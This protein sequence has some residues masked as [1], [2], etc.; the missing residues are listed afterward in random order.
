[1][2]RTAAVSGPLFCAFAIVL[3][4]FGS[5][6]LSDLLTPDRLQTW[7]TAARY[8][9]FQGLGLLTVAGLTHA[10]NLQM[11][12]AVALLITG[13]LMFSFSLIAVVL[14][15]ISTLGAITP[16]GGLLM[17]WGWIDISYRLYKFT[18]SEIQK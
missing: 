5:H 2:N 13:T 10:L 18:Q 11:K 15:N 8:L 17:I 14:T 3:G 6:A 1:M 7:Q 12:R 16:L 4:A 9:M